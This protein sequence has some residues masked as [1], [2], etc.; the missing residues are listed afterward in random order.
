MN[1]IRLKNGV[2]TIID[3]IKMG[4]NGAKFKVLYQNE[5]Y[6]L[7]M[8]EYDYEQELDCS[9]MPYL[10][11]KGNVKYND[12]EYCYRLY[13]L[14]DGR[15]PSQNECLTYEMMLQMIEFEIELHKKN[16]ALIDMQLDNFMVD[17]KNHIFYVDYGGIKNELNAYSSFC[18]P[19]YTI[20]EPEETYGK[21]DNDTPNYN[22]QIEIFYYGLFIKESFSIID[23][24]VKNIIN[25]MTQFKRCNRYRK[26]IDIKK[27]F[28]ENSISA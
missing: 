22:E 8:A 27:D 14:V 23:E 5:L 12:I 15:C 24:K 25:K 9:F 21:M 4:A 20:D 10:S 7:K 11:E 18:R 1:G 19:F 6:F 28:F 17:T 3:E 13:C 26:F 16:H 2:A